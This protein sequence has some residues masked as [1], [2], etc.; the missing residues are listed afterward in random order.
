MTKDFASGHM[1]SRSRYCECV[2]VCVHINTYI[3]VT[4]CACVYVCVR[5]TWLTDAGVVSDLADPR[6][7]TCVLLTSLRCSSGWR[8]SRADETEKRRCSLMIILHSSVAHL[9]SC[10]YIFGA[11]SILLF[12]SYYFVFS[13]FFAII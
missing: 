11:I 13:S 9:F 5:V 3:C 4:V 2:C 1:R 6:R 7:F 10:A 12:F 8:R